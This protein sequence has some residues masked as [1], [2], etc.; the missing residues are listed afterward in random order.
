MQKFSESYNDMLFDRPLTSIFTGAAIAGI[1]F[2]SG[3]LLVPMLGMAGL[4]LVATGL[5]VGVMTSVLGLFSGAAML[6][7]YMGSREFF[8]SEE[9]EKQPLPQ[10]AFS[11]RGPTLDIYK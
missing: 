8:P 3:F 10:Y 6:G 7:S 2:A 11:D 5:C 1:S 4:G 9:P